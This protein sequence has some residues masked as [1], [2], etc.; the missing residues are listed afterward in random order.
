VV[1]GLTSN[2]VGPPGFRDAV[3]HIPAPAGIQAQGG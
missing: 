3:E 2:A 1:C